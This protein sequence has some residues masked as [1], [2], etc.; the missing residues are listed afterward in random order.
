MNYKVQKCE[1]SPYKDC[2]FFEATFSTF[3]Q[4]KNFLA[5]IFYDYCRPRCDDFSILACEQELDNLEEQ[6]ET[7]DFIGIKDFGYIVRI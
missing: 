3:E 7:D 6:E 1:N 5:D 2:D 4:A